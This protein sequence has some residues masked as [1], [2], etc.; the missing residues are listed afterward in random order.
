[1]AI[2][3][4]LRWKLGVFEDMDCSDKSP[5]ILSTA[6]LEGDRKVTRAPGRVPWIMSFTAQFCQRFTF[7]LEMDKQFPTLFLNLL[8]SREQ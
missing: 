2:S 7:I 4:H 3:L 5:S 1:M 8:C 6:Y